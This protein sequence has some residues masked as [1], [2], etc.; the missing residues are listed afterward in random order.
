M[1]LLLC[2][3][4]MR[5][6][7]D[8]GTWQ[9]GGALASTMTPLAM[10]ALV[11]MS[12]SM[13]GLMPRSSFS[14][15]ATGLAALAIAA[16]GVGQTL[17]HDPYL[18][19]ACDQVCTHSALVVWVVPEMAV[20]LANARA[21]L[22]VAVLGVLV[23]AALV[24]GKRSG[25][26]A[27]RALVVTGSV[28]EVSAAATIVGPGASASWLEPEASTVALALLG[29]ACLVLAFA[30]VQLPRTV[31]RLRVRTAVKV[32][33]RSEHAAD[34][35]EV[36]R[37]SLGEPE[38]VV[39]Y[40]VD[41]VGLVDR[42]G[43]GYQ[44]PDGA[45]VTTLHF[46]G[47]PVAAVVHSGSGWV[48][49]LLA[50]ELG[51]RAVI[52]IQNASLRLQLEVALSEV[53][54]SRRRLVAVADTTRR[55]IERDLH[56]G[57]QQRLLAISFDLGRAARAADRVGDLPC[58]RGLRDAEV[59]TAA[60]LSALRAFAVRV[61]PP[62]LETLGVGPALLTRAEALGRS[63]RVA[64]Q[65]VRAPGEV[66]QAAYVILEEALVGHPDTPVRISLHRH[67]GA[68]VC[69]FPGGRVGEHAFDRAAVLHGSIGYEGADGNELVVSLP[70]AS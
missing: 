31:T 11:T 38:L 57:A 53:Y 33:E 20:A 14:R 22:V 4:G 67:D 10:I 26:S 46:Q 36:L 12:L 17:V 5:R 7:I 24:I 15:R 65:S 62:T 8:Q 3:E 39:A 47:E 68:F 35:E 45:A 41:P 1:V 58:A 40:W 13:V 66:E 43:R 44:P 19:L 56:D 70:C 9:A 30:W 63:A 27:P 55:E 64:G 51:P 48:V 21:L 60:V 6:Y 25:W 61:R 18:D 69:R 32:V 50:E 29:V 42:T 59:A 28:A 34:W 2:V 52:S 37:R 16:L 23:V 54:E 49:D